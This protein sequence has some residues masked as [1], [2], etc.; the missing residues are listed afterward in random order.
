MDVC[1]GLT[2]FALIQLMKIG[3]G[4]L[5]ICLPRLIKKYWYE[6]CYYIHI[7]VWHPFSIT[8]NTIDKFL[9]LDMGIHGT[10]EAVGEDIEADFPW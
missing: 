8:N 7:H 5:P 6:F 10:L 1:Y 2:L 4:A 3:K 9:E